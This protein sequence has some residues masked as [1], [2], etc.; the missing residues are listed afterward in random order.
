[1]I[2]QCP[3]CDSRYR[4]NDAN[5]PASGGK[6][7][8]PSCGD[9]F[10]VYPDA[11]DSHTQNSFEDKTSVAKAPA[12]REL[13]NKMS[14]QRT[15]PDDLNAATEVMSSL[16]IPD[17]LTSDTQNIATDGTVE[18]A[19]PDIAQLRAQDQAHQEAD[20]YGGDFASTEILSSDA[21]DS[22]GFHLPSDANDSPHFGE[23]REHAPLRT[24]LESSAATGRLTLTIR[25]RCN[26]PPRASDPR[27]NPRNLAWTIRRFSRRRPNQNRPRCRRCRIPPRCPSPQ[28][29]RSPS[30]RATRSSFLSPIRPLPTPRTKAPGS[31]KRTSG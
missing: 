8:C 29:P 2:V 11:P 30:P 22:L 24:Q 4:V 25:P 31:S 26:P 13:V 5:V 20:E 14:P 17:S 6:I 12:L 19:S 3:N 1:M 16:D 15:E 9:K 7:T 10:I 27:C 28:P 21:L 18:M 23:T